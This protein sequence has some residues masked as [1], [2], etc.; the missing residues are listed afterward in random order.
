MTLSISSSPGDLIVVEG[1]P[2]GG[3]SSTPVN[4]VTDNG[5]NTW[6]IPGSYPSSTPPAAYTGGIGCFL[7]YCNVSS[8]LSSVTVNIPTASEL[9]VCISVYTGVKTSFPL[10]QG[11]GVIASSV[12]LNAL[13]GNLT[14]AG[15]NT[16]NAS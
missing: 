7:A 9:T 16:S 6:A 1:Y 11:T 5:G 3:S 12:S 4:S 14:V 15:A 10:R 8:S 13:G 2:S